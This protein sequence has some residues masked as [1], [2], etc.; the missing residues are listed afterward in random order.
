M[1]NTAL[2]LVILG[3]INWLLIGLFSFDLVGSILG[4]QLSVLARIVFVIVG[5]AGLWSINLLFK[6]KVPRHDH[7]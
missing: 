2:I 7:A 6:D 4:G 3:A 5:I 1:N